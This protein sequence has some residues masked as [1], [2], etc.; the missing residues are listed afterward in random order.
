MDIL[1][2]KHD[3]VISLG[4]TCFI[5]QFLRRSG[6]DQKT[7][8]FDWIGSSMWGICDLIKYDFIN[9]FNRDD[10]KYALTMKTDY[11]MVINTLY[12]IL[13][14]HDF[15]SSLP[16]DQ[17]N[18]VQQNIV[19][20]NDVQ[21]S[22]HI[23]DNAFLEFQQKYA[24][25]IIEL[26]ELLNDSKKILFI[27]HEQYMENRIIYSAYEKQFETSELQYLIEFTKLLKVLHPVLKF[28]II[29]ISHTLQ[30]E[31][32]QEH[33]IT[34]LHGSIV[35]WENCVEVYNKLFEDNRKFISILDL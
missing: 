18:I 22:M 17:Q 10:Y 11:I 15:P 12:Y 4:A 14:R 29:F 32:L 24:K 5:K 26:K 34:I 2:N 21:H 7:Y 9:M 28:N 20:L 30:T 35:N 23:N 6:I 27:R 8:I 33:N 31:H 3:I 25:R 16:G 13:F 1:K 19:Q